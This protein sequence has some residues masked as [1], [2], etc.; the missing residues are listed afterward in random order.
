[1]TNV[2]STATNTG[3]HNGSEAPSLLP[4][5]FT[6]ATVA[7]NGIR[8]HYVLGGQGEPLVLVHGWPQTWY[9]WHRLM[10]AL[11]AHY[12]VIVPDLR[13]AGLSDK[14]APAMG[15]DAYTLA[16]DLHQLVQQLG[17]SS[18]RLVGHDIGAMVAYA[19]AATHP[20][21][22][23]RLGLFDGPLL[24]VGPQLPPR[25]GI[26]HPGFHM[27][28]ALPELLT[29]GRERDYLTY[30]FTHFAYDKTAFSTAEVDE[31]VRAYSAPGA[32]SAGFEWYRAFPATAAR[33]QVS[34][35]TKL[36]MPV[37]AL[38]GQHSAGPTIVATVQA[39][40]DDVRGGS[41]P[42]AGHWLAEENPAYLLD[43]LIAFL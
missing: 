19:Y 27:T 14:P 18:I 10:P 40:A 1:M 21:E 32:M 6:E 36:A 26:W 16:D 3:H 11:A 28:P 13:G 5:G 9:A 41:V 39:V 4:A 24:G 35:Q 33:N 37:L 20:T 38:G 42:N 25:P 23:Y 29:A 34:A 12:T 17:F 43:Q 30:F 22:V 8:I 31:F 15:Y 7:V 2:S